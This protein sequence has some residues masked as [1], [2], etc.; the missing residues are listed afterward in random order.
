MA[1]TQEMA[2]RRL[3]SILNDG[4]APRAQHRGGAQ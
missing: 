3:V 1:R 4:P 2:E